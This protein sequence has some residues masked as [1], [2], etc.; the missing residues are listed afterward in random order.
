MAHPITT[1]PPPPP[2]KQALAWKR[3]EIICLMKKEMEL[4]SRDT[5]YGLTFDSS[6]TKI[7]FLIEE[8]EKTNE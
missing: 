2:A 4:L 6:W 5:C 1:T 8:M 3:W 7:E